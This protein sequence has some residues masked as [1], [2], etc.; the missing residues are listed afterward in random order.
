[1]DGAIVGIA[2]AP[3]TWHVWEHKCTNENKFRKL[4]RLKL[5]HG[6]KN[7]LAEWD[8][9][10]FV[11]AVLYMH[12]AEMARHYL[13]VASCGSRKYTSC[14]TDANPTVAKELI[15]KAEMI[16]TYQIPLD[17]I[18]TK[19]DYYQCGWC[20]HNDLCH[21]HG[22]PIPTC[23]TC[24]Y[25]A[26]QMNGEDGAW[27]CSA[28]QKNIPFDEQLK[29]CEHH[30]FVPVLLESFATQEDATHDGVK[31]ILKANGMEFWNGIKGDNAYSSREIHNCQ[32]KTILG[33]KNVEL[34]RQDFGAKIDG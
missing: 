21:G 10:Y 15:D 1:M 13:T 16:I 33:E 32:I 19:P 6:D 26:P 27:Q 29:G 25:A 20:P 22:A 8:F 4:D 9:V 17:K 23:R 18:S 34:L 11:Q 31:Y 24:I 12:Y 30:T 28:H 2:Q 3:K 5:K 7:A 14:R